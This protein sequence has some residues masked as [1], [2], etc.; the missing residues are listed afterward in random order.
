MS[1]TAVSSSNFHLIFD[2]ALAD[3]LGQTGV[4][5]SK[6]SF[7]EKL[8]TCQSVDA[9]FELL[10]DKA[11]QFKDYRNGDRKLIS[12]LNPIVQVLYGF[13]SVLGGP[14]STVG[15]LSSSIL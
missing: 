7:S 4:D 9:V 1:V 15:V 11:K 5:L 8:Q 6:D 10:Q 2:A 14:A 13:S 12:Y 3:Y